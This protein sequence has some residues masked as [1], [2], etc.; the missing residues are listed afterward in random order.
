MDI[1]RLS[2]RKAPK[3]SKIILK[4]IDACDSKISKLLKKL[5]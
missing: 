2:L 5:N 1:L 3:E 4:N